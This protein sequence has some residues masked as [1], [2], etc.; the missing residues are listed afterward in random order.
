MIRC[1]SLSGGTDGFGPVSEDGDLK[2]G[3]DLREIPWSKIAEAVEVVQKGIAKRVDVEG[4]IAYAQVGHMMGFRKPG[5]ALMVRVGK[6][7]AGRL[8]DGRTWE[9]MPGAQS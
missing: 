3:I 2:G 9:E 8:L 4:N 1:Q 6:K 7:A 5:E